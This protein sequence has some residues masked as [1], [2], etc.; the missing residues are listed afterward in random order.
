MHD[1]RL[2]RYARELKEYLASGALMGSGAVELTDGLVV[3]VERMAR[4]TLAEFE[5]LASGTSQ[6]SSIQE[7]QQLYADLERL[8]AFVLS[9]SS[10]VGPDR[11]PHPASVLGLSAEVVQRI[12]QAGTLE[13]ATATGR[14]GDV[15]IVPP[16]EDTVSDAAGA[17]AEAPVS[18]LSFSA[19]EDL[20]AR[21]AATIQATLS[22]I[23][24]DLMARQWTLE[25]QTEEDRTQV[26]LLT[27]LSS[28]LSH[29]QE[30]LQ[31]LRDLTASTH[32]TARASLMLLAGII[33]VLVGGAVWWLFHAV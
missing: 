1:P 29:A 14:P 12:I 24:A 17:S 19:G 33:A 25:R 15:T 26:D 13:V 28:D 20:A 10:A 4:I 18:A 9:R 31:E 27:R 22:P 11:A 32:R 6:T 21:V 3:D 2:E 16:V 5:R 8:H 7:H 23:M 30:T